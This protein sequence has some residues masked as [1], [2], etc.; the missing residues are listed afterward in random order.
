MRKLTF[1]FALLCVSVMGWATQYCG[2]TITATDGVTTVTITCTN[3]ETDKYVMEI[4]GGD[5]FS[6]LIGA[7]NYCHVN[8]AG[9]NLQVQMSDDFV[10]FDNETKTLT[11][12]L[13]STG[14]YAPVFYN[15]LYLNI[16]GEKQFTAIQNQTF[17]WPASCASAGDDPVDPTPEPAVEGEKF[18]AA[19]YDACDSWFAIPQWQQENNS[20]ATCTDGV[21]TVNINETKGAQWHAQVSLTLD[22]DFAANKYYDFSIKFHSNNAVNNVSFK[23]NDK[24]GDNEM[25][26]VSD[27]AIPANEDYVYTKT[28]VAG[29]ANGSRKFL[30]DFG[31]APVGTIITIS[32]ISI[33]EK[34]A[35]SVEPAAFSINFVSGQ[36]SAVPNED[37]FDVNIASHGGGQWSRQVKFQHLIAFENTK[38]Y[39]VAFTLTADKDCGGITFKTDDNKEC[40]YEN[41][42]ID[43][44]A[45]TP[46]QY[47]KVFSGQP[48]NNKIMVFDFGWVGENTN[49]TISDLS[50]IEYSPATASSTNGDLIPFKGV[51][52]KTNTRWQAASTGEQW[53]KM[54]YGTA[55]SF[56]RVNITWE[57]SY[58]KSFTIQGSNDDENYTILKT[59]TSQ[60][61][62][63]PNNYKQVIDLDQTY[64]FRYVKFVGTEN[65]NGYGFS[66]YE[67]EVLEAETSILTDVVI[68]SPKRKTVCAVGQSIDITAVA[69]DQYEELMDGQTITYSVSPAEKGSID[70]NGHYTANAVG[71]VT[72][73]ATCFDKSATAV[74]ENTISANLALNKPAA[75]GANENP[76][77]R[78]NDND[79]GTEWSL[80]PNQAVADMW[81]KVDLEDTYDLSLVIIKWE[82]ACPT[83]HAI[84]VSANGTDWTDAATKSGW[85]EIGTA[86]DHN[87]QFYPINETGRY[88]R[89]K[90]SALRE[91][92]WGMKIYDFQAFGTLA[93]TPTKSVSATPNDEL[94]GSATVKQSGVA[95]T[96]VTTG[97][98]VEFS[99]EANEGYVFVN[100]SN[101]ETHATFTTNVETNMDLTAN[102]RALG[103]VYCNTLLQSTDRGDGV[104]SA[105][106]TFKKT[107]ENTYQLIV[108]SEERLNNFGGADFYING[109]NTVYSMRN[110]G[111][112]S[113]NDHTLT[114]TITSSAAPIMA[115]GY[116]YVTVKDFTTYDEAFFPKLTNIEF[117]SQCDDN[118]S[119]TAIALSQSSAKLLI[120]HTLT[121]T[122]TFTPVYASDN[123]LT[124]E[125]SNPS[126]ATV[127]NG[128]VTGV[129]DG[130][131]T[132]T[133][134]L[135]SDNSVYATCNVN[136][137]SSITEAT[138]HGYEFV[139]PQEGPTVF[140]YAI[141]RSVDQKLTFTM[142]TD[143][144]VIGFVA[145]IK[146]NGTD[147]QLEGYGAEH[148]ASYTTTGTYEDNVLLNCMWDFRSALYR[149]TF[150]FTYLVGTENAALKIMTLDENADD[151]TAIIEPFDGQNVNLSIV[152]RSFVADNLYTL[153]L[154]FDADAAQT[155]AKLPGKLTKLSNTYV[156]ENKDLR[157][158]FVDAEAIEA[159]VP[160]LYTPS[161]DV[162]NAI[163]ENVT[164]SKDLH[165]TV[166]ADGLAE[167]HGIY[168]PTTGSA[169]KTIPNAYVL[170]SDQYLYDVQTLSDEQQMKALRGYFVLN[171]PPQSLGMRARVVFNSQETEVATGISDVQSD[172]Q[173]TKVIRDGQLLI[174]RDGKTYNVQG[175]LIK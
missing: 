126:V 175:Q 91:N 49:I 120:D 148:T 155:A 50:L 48:D 162:T 73:T 110:T 10:S 43:L 32:E 77:S 119:V 9:T 90:A 138:W 89:V 113:D 168:A 134:K 133:A 124:W 81:W 28:D 15:P 85:P 19:N 80:G 7:G 158:N 58:A 139:S 102:F 129:A 142:T 108:K 69:R 4:V 68:T 20:T 101:G 143:K 121:L 95:V 132:I 76:V 62:D 107:G 44:T 79:L 56:N 128:V 122:P 114:G 174:L 46:F 64:N 72:I 42:S 88:I 99:A 37:D 40:V 116:T 57:F 33:I 31:Y 8:D 1:L 35:P 2:E 87:Y 172:I 93:S 165:A 118:V 45:N 27:I 136:V 150:D 167:Y 173:C 98:E 127:A 117:E 166:P 17:E 161:A 47:E 6:G 30:L 59:I 149:E 140:T 14:G 26:A 163:F 54:D 137:V 109:N 18:I 94:M 141:T 170:G 147:H 86:Q 164:V 144:N 106:F 135:T 78:A 104:H 111:V 60:T 169:L 145:F 97:S 74:V 5:K 153:V 171:F 82:G 12:T 13:T 131:T 70:A 16:E 39:K 65:G 55:Q 25:L 160:Y 75:A 3:P 152:N 67:F 156:K 84:Q 103:T 159:G 38:A 53:W 157:V 83:E 96:N 151:N 112:L 51:D 123:E 21:I 146:I 52:G 105:Y 66:F 22:F 100:W 63:N 24:R 130:N 61:L 11:V 34:D 92:G 154:P 115:S 36:V 23:P 41:Q 125:T 71:E 29:T